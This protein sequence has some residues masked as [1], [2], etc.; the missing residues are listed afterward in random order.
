MTRI[1]L[2]GMPGS[3]KSS[4]ARQL[5]RRLHLPMVDTDD[6]IESRECRSIA[7]IFAAEGEAYFRDLEEAVIHEVTQREAVVISTGGGAVL[8]RA[9][10]MALRERCHV[11]YLRASPD[12]LH[13]RL[14]RTTHRPL[15]QVPNPAAR[16]RELH[17]ARDPLYREAAHYVVDTGR[18]SVGALSNMVVS[19]L[20]LAGLWPAT[21]A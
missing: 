13:R 12:E 17:A 16:V 20:E 15:L 11:F 1:A 5:A 7:E 18:P 10:R 4:V 6:L 3:G 2:I 21:Q 8:R 14:K 19:Q 9:N